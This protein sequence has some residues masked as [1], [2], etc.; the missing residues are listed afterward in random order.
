MT[1]GDETDSTTTESTNDQ[2][3]DPTEMQAELDRLNEKI[4]TM[5]ENAEESNSGGGG[6]GGGDGS[7]FDAPDVKWWQAAGVGGAFLGGL[8]LLSGGS[9]GKEPPGRSR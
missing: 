5:Q 4:N 9:V 2:N 7:G 3:Y 1:T 6:G 8:Y